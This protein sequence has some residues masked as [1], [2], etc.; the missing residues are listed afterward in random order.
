[1]VF[2]FRHDPS[3]RG[4]AAACRLASR[5][6][7]HHTRASGIVFEQSLRAQRCRLPVAPGAI[8]GGSYT[9]RFDGKDYPYKGDAG[10]STVS[11]RKI[12]ANTIE[13]TF[14]LGSKVIGVARTSI[15]AGGRS[16]SVSFKDVARDV[17]MKWM[18]DKK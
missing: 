7:G 13:E 17:T 4:P 6:V 15:A 12:D 10:I 1:V 9:A 8:T 14:K 18:A 16:L 5:K 2:D 3:G 11:L